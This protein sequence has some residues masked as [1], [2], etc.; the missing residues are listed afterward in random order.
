MSMVMELSHALA[1]NMGWPSL[2][3]ILAYPASA[4]LGT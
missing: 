2:A 3:P 4:G 1:V